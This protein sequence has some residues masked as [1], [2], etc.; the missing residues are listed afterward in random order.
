VDTEVVSHCSVF[1]AQSLQLLISKYDRDLH[2][3]SSVM[4][5]YCVKQIEMS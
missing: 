1:S 2:F 3:S 5:A 4:V